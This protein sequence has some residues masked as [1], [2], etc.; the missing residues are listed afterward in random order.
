MDKCKENLNYLEVK[1][2]IHNE[3]GINKGYIQDVIKET[4]CSEVA[5]LMKDTGFLNGIIKSQVKDILNKEYTKPNY[6]KLFSL[7]ELIYDKVCQEI[8]KTVSNNIQIKVGLNQENLEVYKF[9]EA[10]PFGYMEE[11]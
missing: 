8:S 3:L 9:D 7:N 1:N 11:D 4:V 2:Y 10:R 6:Q 5:K